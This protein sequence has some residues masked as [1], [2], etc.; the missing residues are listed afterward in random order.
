MFGGYLQLVQLLKNNFDDLFK[1]IAFLHTHAAATNTFKSGFYTCLAG[2][3]LGPLQIQVTA[4]SL[5]E[6]SR[7]PFKKIHFIVP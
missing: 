5:T 6:N 2:L 7:E 4:I 1:L 3:F